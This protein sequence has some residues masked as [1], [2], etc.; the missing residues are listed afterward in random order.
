MFKACSAATHTAGRPAREGFEN[1]QN[2]L[3]LE[4]CF[5]HFNSKEEANAK[6][7]LEAEFPKSANPI[8]RD[9]FGSCFD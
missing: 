6:R 7:N 5:K 3:D 4:I 9:G 2:L 1:A 8:E